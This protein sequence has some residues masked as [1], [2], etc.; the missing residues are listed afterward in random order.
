MTENG[1]GSTA[2]DIVKKYTE[3]KIGNFPGTERMGAG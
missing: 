2:Y 1:K 3:E